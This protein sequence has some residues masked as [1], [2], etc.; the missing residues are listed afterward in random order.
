MTITVSSLMATVDKTLDEK[1]AHV[2]RVYG[3]HWEARADVIRS[4]V[5][6]GAA[7]FAGTVTFVHRTP[8]VLCTIERWSLVASWVLLIAST[9]SGL[10]VLWQSVTLRSFYPKL[11]NSRPQL[12]QQFEALDLTLPDAAAQSAAILKSAVDAVV[13]PMGLADSLAQ[14][15]ARVC[16]IS[17]LGSMFLVYAGWRVVS[18]S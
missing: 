3:P 9:S 16:L 11:L 18:G 17:F 14:L 12:R 2:D 15:A 5:A 7:I 8:S 1:A 10:F 13:N 4:L 6:V